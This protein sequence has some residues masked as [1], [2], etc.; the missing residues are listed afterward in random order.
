MPVSSS[1]LCQISL[2]SAEDSAEALMI[3]TFPGHGLTFHG[4]KSGPVPAKRPPGPAPAQEHFDGRARLFARLSEPYSVM[5]VL[6]HHSLV[7][8]AL[9]SDVAM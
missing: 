6:T 5:Y 2:E 8:T 9:L 4:L 1:L 3:S 7:S